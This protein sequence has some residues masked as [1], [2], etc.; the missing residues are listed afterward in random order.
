MFRQGSRFGMEYRAAKR[1]IPHAHLLLWVED[2]AC[3]Q[4]R[5]LMNMSM[6]RFPMIRT[7]F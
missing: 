4:V 7:Q 3:L 2:M 1:G 6:Q 5:E